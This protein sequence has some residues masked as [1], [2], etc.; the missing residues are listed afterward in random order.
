MWYELLIVGN[1][2]AYYVNLWCESMD[3]VVYE[4]TNG[5][6]RRKKQIV[7][8]RPLLYKR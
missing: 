6:P 1:L 4:W 5:N 7:R 8:I 2:E 3:D